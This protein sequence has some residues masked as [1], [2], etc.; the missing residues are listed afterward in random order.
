MRRRSRPPDER[1]GSVL[2]DLDL[3][4]QICDLKSDGPLA[5][6]TLQSLVRE[7]L[8]APLPQRIFSPFLMAGWESRVCGAEIGISAQRSAICAGEYPFSHLLRGES[9]R[10]FSSR[11]GNPVFYGAEIGISAQRCSSRDGNPVFYGAE[12]GI[13]AQRVCGSG[14][15]ILARRRG[16]PGRSL[17]GC[18]DHFFQLARS[19][20][21]PS[22]PSGPRLQRS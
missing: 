1:V 6:E 8:L 3:Q 7:S 11:D 15:G 2:A 9:F 19:S 13:S 18:R 14:M 4:S 20:V 10:H 16:P 12:I 22:W 17:P 5:R 21:V